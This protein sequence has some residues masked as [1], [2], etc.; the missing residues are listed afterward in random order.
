MKQKTAAI[1]SVVDHSPRRADADEDVAG[2]RGHPR[3]V[4][5]GA[6]GAPRLGAGGGRSA[7]AAGTDT[8]SQCAADDQRQAGE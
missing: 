7:G 8:V 6:A 4:G 3:R 2:S 5:P 1:S